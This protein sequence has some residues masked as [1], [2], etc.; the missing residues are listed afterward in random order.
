[1]LY[2]WN[3]IG[4]DTQIRQL[5]YD[6]KNNNLA[7]AYLF[8][9]PSRIGKFS[10]TKMFAHILQCP[11]NFCH[12]CKTCQE[13]DKN[14]HSDTVI[15]ED[16]HESS[17]KIEQIRD[18]ITKL[19]MSSQSIYKILIVQNIERMTPEAVNALLKTLEEPP[20][21]TIFLFT[22]LTVKS[23]MPTFVSRVRV[24]RF[25]RISE[26]LLYDYLN[27]KFP[28]L[29]L[30]ELKE[31]AFFSF[32][33]PGQGAMLASD[34]DLL[35]YYRDL[36]AKVRAFLTESS[37]ADRFAFVQELSLEQRNLEDFLDV[38]IASLR[39]LVLTKKSEHAISL[40]ESVHEAQRLLKNN[41]NTKLALE[42][43]MLNF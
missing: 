25:H 10:C 22:T 29:S 37:V 26:E 28:D 14:M 4:H 8:S 41:I 9:G 23:L 2:K 19:N 27:K 17:V 1:M 35:Q 39:H 33:K 18:I 43:L 13:I 20:S 32:G 40:I 6:L 21:K 5:E 31:I 42:N 38:L 16:D 34:P 15:L 3:I 30:D 11:N 12:E 24:I 36:Y 7:H